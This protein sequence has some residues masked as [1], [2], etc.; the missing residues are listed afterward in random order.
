MELD[1]VARDIVLANIR[2]SLPSRWSRKVEEL[3]AIARTNDD[4]TLATFLREAEHDIEDVYQGTKSW[5]DL[6]VAAG[7][8]VEPEGPHEPALRRACGR[9]L[10]VDDRTRLDS[11]RRFLSSDRLPIVEALP[12]RNAD[13]CE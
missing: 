2:Q 12:E 4:V 6:R 11:Y 9:V 1:H 5:S 10:H 7:L 13:S 3:R 8:K